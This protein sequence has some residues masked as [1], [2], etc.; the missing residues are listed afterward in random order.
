MTQSLTAAISATVAAL[1]AASPAAAAPSAAEI[2]AATY[3]GGDLPEDQS[4]LTV[5][6][7]ALL[8][9]AGISPGVIDG[10]KGGMSTSALTAFERREGL[11]EDGV[12]DPQV[13]D[14]LG[15]ANAGP[16]VTRYTITAEDSA[17]LSDPLPDDYADLAELEWL[18]YTSLSEKLAERFHMDEDFLIA[19]NSGASFS[20]GETIQVIDPGSDLTGTVARV[21][22]DKGRNRALA[23]D[24]QGK[25]LSDYPVTI[26]SDQTPSPEGIVEVEAI[27]VE[28]NYSY[29][30]DVNFQQGDND[31]FLRLPPGPNGPVGRIWIDLSKPTYGLHGTPSPS[32][33]FTRASHGCVRFTNWDA[34]ELAHMIEVGATVEFIE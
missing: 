32:E 25:V 22:I 5:K 18:G 34:T 7:Q 11:P 30:P 19:L 17:D 14:A 28:P 20:T 2:D 21:V 23:M 9:R 13:W 10:W 31:E 3:E 33:L 8:D 4:A 12:L 15:G 24:A 6:V 27:A 29:N 1:V 16:V 26:G